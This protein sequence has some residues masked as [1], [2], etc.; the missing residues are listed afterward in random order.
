MD[1]KTRKQLQEK[2]KQRMLQLPPIFNEFLQANQKNYRWLVAL[3][4]QKISIYLQTIYERRINK[5]LM[6]S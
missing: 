5:R 6:T 2:L 3:S 4:M 1:M